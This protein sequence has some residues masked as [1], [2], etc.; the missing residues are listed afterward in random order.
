MG[1]TAGG[2]YVSVRAQQPASALVL[3]GAAPGS[4][5]G[6]ATSAAVA[7]AIAAMDSVGSAADGVILAELGCERGRGPT[8]LATDR[9]R[10]LER[11]L[12]EPGLE[13]AARGRLAWLRLGADE[14]WDESLRLA[15]D[16]A[17]PVRAVVVHLPARHWREALEPGRLNPT[18]ALLRADLPAQRSL[19]ALAVVELG[20][21]GLR[22]RV[23][24]RAP[25][26]VAGRRALA[27]IE[28]GGD[29]SERATRLA[30]GL[31]SPPRRPTPQAPL[32]ALRARLA[33]ESGQALPLA[34]GS[35]LALIFCALLLAAF[36]GA[37][38]GKSRVQRVADLTALS[39][40][41]SM[42]DDFER[43][44]AAARRADGSPNPQHLSKADYLSRASLAGAQAAQR[45]GVDPGRL[46]L[47]FPDAAS[48]APLRVQATISTELE[49]VAP[50]PKL[51]VEAQAEAEAVPSSSASSP[52]GAEAT[53]TGG[54]YAGIL[55]YRQGEGMR[56]DVATAYD[57]M[58]AAAS[59]DGVHLIVNSG[60]RSDA[61]QAE[62]YAANPDP[63]WVAPPG[64]SLHR[65]ATELDLG[66]SS[67]YGWLAANAPRFGFAKRYS[68]EPWH[69]GFDRPPGPCSAAGDGVEAGAVSRAGEGSAEEA[70]ALPSFVP[71][72]FQAPL[73]RAASR[74]NVS[75]AL[76]AA[77]LLAESNFNPFAV[78]PA[79]AQGIA[80][81]MPGTAAAYG[82]TDPFDAAAAIDAQARLMADLLEQF[83]GRVELALAAYNAGPAPVEACACVPDY[84]E[85][86]AYVARI[87][88]LIG[89][90]GAITTAPALEVRLV[91]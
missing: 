72:R 41:R 77:Q 86:Q 55:E 43:L 47:E 11:A 42:R 6:L 38:T 45:N 33:S 20:A 19:A 85:T 17:G 32:G 36:G 7:V 53:A 65:C 57:R 27:G 30:R 79:G 22:V 88:A 70:G 25:G 44:F 48:F 34:L 39:A 73:A 46:E 16:A 56:P 52:P 15:L 63:R 71:V 51:P 68:W 76:L 10:E 29:A 49:P 31:T 62:L 8:M 60:F 59:A 82:L 1:E 80:Q 5:G 54:G 26:R 35:A 90:A 81:F 40:A 24:S 67:A 75:A 69:F 13:A 12:R 83:D 58:A 84:Y 18:G 14:H 50:I 23:A 91:G 9:A 37:V 28:A 4:A 78:S 61:E 3:A 87:M 89:G 2:A 74:W 64:T 21:L 66:P